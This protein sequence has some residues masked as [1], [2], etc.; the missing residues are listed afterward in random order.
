VLANYLIGLREGLE[1][2]LV[3]S[4]L[5]A[6]LVKVGRRDRLPVVGI[7]VAAALAV[8]VAFG[9][10]LTYTSTTLLSTFTSQE[11]F[12]GTMSAVAVC[13]VTW[14]IFWMRRTARGMRAE[15]DGR[16]SAAL[17]LGGL[18]VAV[19]AFFAVAREG[20]ETALFFWS[21][22]QAA[23]STTAPVSGFVLGLGTALLLAWLLYR[24]SV[25][26]NLATFFTWTGAGLIVIAAGV[27]GYAV[28][29]LQEGGVIGGLNTLAFDVSNQI[30]PGS[31]YGT[32]L[33]GILNFS[34]QTTLVQAVAWLTY[35]VTVMTFFLLAGKPAPAKA[36]AVHADS[37]V[38]VG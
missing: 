28:H 3:V 10:V 30:P 11:I 37:G 29:D 38:S 17:E 7:G 1:A 8:S 34:P 36:A 5:I 24:R 16:L 21:A 18:A 15:L 13:F 23:G 12:G 33:K 9:A 4:I 22:V 6:Y 35:L 31:W 27:L 2:A 26:L 19:T 14:M 25:R 32:L 20:L